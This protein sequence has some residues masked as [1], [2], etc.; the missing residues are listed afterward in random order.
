M[1]EKYFFYFPSSSV[2]VLRVCS[3]DVSRFV[4][5]GKPSHFYF[6]TKEI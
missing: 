4:Y 5:L 6:I 1:T 3:P 2:P